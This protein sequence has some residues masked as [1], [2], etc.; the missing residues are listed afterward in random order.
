MRNTQTRGVKI[1]ADVFLFARDLCFLVCFLRVSTP[2]PW[3]NSDGGMFLRRN[4]P[5]RLS[6]P[7]CI[8]EVPRWPPSLLMHGGGAR[9]DNDLYILN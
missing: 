7:F 4:L 5:V 3:P 6:Q 1:D 2:P 9:A 8:L